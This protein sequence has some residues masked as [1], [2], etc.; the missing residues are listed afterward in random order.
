MRISDGAQMTVNV[1]SRLPFQG[2][3]LKGRR[4]TPFPRIVLQITLRLP[5][6]L[7]FGDPEISERSVSK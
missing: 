2:F 5:I 3:W 6:V 1:M 7:S 4:E